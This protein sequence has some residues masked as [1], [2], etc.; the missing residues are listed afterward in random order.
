MQIMDIPEHSVCW[1]ALFHALMVPMENSVQH[2]NQAPSQVE[3]RLAH[4]PTRSPFPCQLPNHQ[5]L[6]FVPN[7]KIKGNH[8]NIHSL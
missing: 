1:V 3:D 6:H 7:K 8:C 4:Y 2:P 5:A